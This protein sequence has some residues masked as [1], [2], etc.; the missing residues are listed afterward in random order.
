MIVQ[1]AWPP[2]HVIAENGNGS[3]NQNSNGEIQYEIIEAH[4]LKA[5]N[6]RRVHVTTTTMQPTLAGNGHTVHHHQI[7]TT[8]KVKKTCQMAPSSSASSSKS[9][10][11]DKPRICHVCGEMAG[12]H[13]YYG[14][15]V[16]P[17]CRAFFRRSVQSK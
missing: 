2:Q 1:P 15:Q 10:K 6:L 13:S 8:S 7:P 14:G 16:C 17:S 4:E 5:A 12:K 3:A 11:D 9:G